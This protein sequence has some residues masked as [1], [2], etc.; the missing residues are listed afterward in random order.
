MVERTMEARV[1]D[2]EKL[3]EKMAPLPERMGEMSQRL[4]VVEGRL[5]AVEGRLGVVES[6]ILQ[7]RTDL[8]GRTTAILDVIDSSSKATQKLVD[9][10]LEAVTSGDE[11][12]R[13]EM[14]LLHKDLVTRITRLGESRRDQ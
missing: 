11:E 10:V 6:Q 4:G 1:M 8:D 7:L 2:L 13:R 3:A 12:T 14:R 5:G 9:E